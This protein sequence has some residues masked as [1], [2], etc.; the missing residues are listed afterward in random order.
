MKKESIEALERSLISINDKPT[1]E[2]IRRAFAQGGYQA[3]RRW[4]IADAEKKAKS[5]YVSPMLL[6]NLYAQ[7]GQREPTLAL[8]E[9]GFRDRDPRL[10]DVQNDPAFDFLHSDERYR[11][12]IRRIGLPPAW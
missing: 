3:A 6:A 10:L 1:A 9:A 7:L 4:Q 12:I 5:Q 8:L 2:G 11:T